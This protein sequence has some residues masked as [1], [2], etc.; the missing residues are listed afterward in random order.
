MIRFLPQLKPKYY[1]NTGETKALNTR[2]S[3]STSIKGSDRARGTRGELQFRMHRTNSWHVWF[4]QLLE[5]QKWMKTPFDIC[6]LQVKQPGNW[7]HS[8]ATLTHEIYIS[9]VCADP[10][11]HPAHLHYFKVWNSSSGQVWEITFWVHLKLHLHHTVK[12]SFCCFCVLTSNYGNK[13]SPT[14]YSNHNMMQSHLKKAKKSLL[15]LLIQ[16]HILIKFKLH[17]TSACLKPTEL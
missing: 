11:I 7:V 5:V 3:N 6:C 13:H 8:L 10:K 17:N 14:K 16:E 1:H 15:N 4:R 9:P 12:H 2:S